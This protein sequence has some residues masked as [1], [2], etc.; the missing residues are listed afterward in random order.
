MW[1]WCL[2]RDSSSLSKLLLLTTVDEKVLGALALATYN[3][4]PFEVIK[5]Q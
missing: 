5:P 2:L 1:G 3:Q 4:T